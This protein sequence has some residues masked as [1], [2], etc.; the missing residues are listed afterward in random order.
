MSIQCLF[1]IRCSLWHRTYTL[2]SEQAYPLLYVTPAPLF[3]PS[4]SDGQ[5]HSR[6]QL[7]WGGGGGVRC[8]GSFLEKKQCIALYQ[9]VIVQNWK[10]QSPC[11]TSGGEGSP[12]EIKRNEVREIQTVENDASF[13]SPGD[14]TP[15]GQPRAIHIVLTSFVHD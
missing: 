13:H 11:R 6:E 8:K 15:A 5:Y 3:C 12:G 2:F 9:W 10:P 1:Q 4:I 14:E 7:P